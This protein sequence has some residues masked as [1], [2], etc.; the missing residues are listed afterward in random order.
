MS[1]YEAPKLLV[2]IC[3]FEESNWV[4]KLT[5]GAVGYSRV[6]AQNA[7]TSIPT[8]KATSKPE[9]IR[10][11]LLLAFF[12][13]L[14]CIGFSVKILRIVHVYHRQAPRRVFDDCAVA[15]AHIQKM[16]AQ[17]LVTVTILP[18]LKSKT[19]DLENIYS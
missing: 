15:V 16:Y 10:I 4:G 7:Q 2:R 3:G 8:E 9:G 17:H 6:L 1:E 18:R 12:F 11:A 5:L 14:F 13:Q 19:D